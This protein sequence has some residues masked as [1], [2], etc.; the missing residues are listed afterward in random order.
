MSPVDLDG[1]AALAARH[2]LLTHRDYL[3]GLAAENA[4]LR[5]TLDRQREVRRK[6]R[7]RIDALTDKLE[8]QR[9]RADRLQAELDEARTAESRGR[10]GVKPFRS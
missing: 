7:Q 8:R 6:Q 10:R 9:R 5:A 3:I 2:D 1:A 4:S